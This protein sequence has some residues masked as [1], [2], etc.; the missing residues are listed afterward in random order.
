MPNRLTRDEA[1]RGTQLADQV[2]D[3]FAF[4]LVGFVAALAS[5]KNQRL[6]DMA[7]GTTVIKK[8]PRLTLDETLAKI[9]AVARG[10]VWSGAQA[11][12]RGTGAK[13]EVAA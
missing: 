13:P 8:K 5:S 12:E 11:L 6:G 3:G 2:V 9:D 10:R 1:E 4:Y 7:A